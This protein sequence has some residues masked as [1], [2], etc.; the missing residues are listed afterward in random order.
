M[1]DGRKSADQF[2]AGT[3]YQNNFS[4]KSSWYVRDEGGFDRIKDIELYNVAAFGMGYDIIKA[5]KQTMTCRAG[6]SFRY[7]GYK[8]PRT[9][10][11]KSAGL[12]FGFAHR[13]ELGDSQIIN[14]LTYVPSFE[15]FNNYRLTH[16]SFYEMPLVNPSWKLRLGVANDYNSK[17]GLGVEKMDT[18]Y[19]T[20]F[21]LNWR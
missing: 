10:D 16:E 3:D 7:E 20:R 12:D 4:G 11:V 17:P 1:T 8:N 15:D 2:K 9:R 18:S 14:R 6:L 5:P 13:L 21:V 19:F